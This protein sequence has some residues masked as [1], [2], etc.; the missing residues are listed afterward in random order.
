MDAD[1]GVIIDARTAPERILKVRG[2]EVYRLPRFSV[3]AKGTRFVFLRISACGQ[4]YN[5]RNRGV[6]HCVVLWA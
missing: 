5:G 2:H 4:L 1:W 6:V 3:P